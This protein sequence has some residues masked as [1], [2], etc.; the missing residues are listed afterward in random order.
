MS[1]TISGLT[2]STFDEPA[3]PEEPSLFGDFSSFLGGFLGAPSTPL[4]RLFQ[5]DF[6]DIQERLFNGL[7]NDIHDAIL[8][9]LGL[10]DPHST[11]NAGAGDAAGGGLENLRLTLDYVQVNQALD[12][13]GDHAEIDFNFNA[14]GQTW[15]YYKESINER[16]D[17]VPMDHVFN[18]YNW[19]P[20]VNLLITTSGKEVDPGI[21]ADDPLPKVTTV[22]TKEDL[23][24]H[25]FTTTARNSDGSFDLVYHWS[26]DVTPAS[27]TGAAAA[28]AATPNQDTLLAAAATP[29]QDALLA[30]AG[31]PS[32]DALLAA[33]AA[34]NHDM[35]LA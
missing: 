5:S 32:Q 8:E 22:L 9:R 15:S 20:N 30:A 6:G 31:A 28:A 25:D 27:N 13:N 18:L 2:Q 11:P 26:L 33:A 35:L 4:A 12:G 29:N 19:D 23:R 34:P 1:E 21:Q 14:G 24:D 3:G 17:V 7:R 10:Q 16:G